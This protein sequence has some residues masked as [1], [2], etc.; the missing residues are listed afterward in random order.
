MRIRDMHKCSVL[1]REESDLKRGLTED[2]FVK[3][4]HLQGTIHPFMCNAISSLKP[5]L[6]LPNQYSE[7][8]P[9]A[10]R[11]CNAVKLNKNCHSRRC[12]QML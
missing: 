2:F 8:F 11:T 12:Y 5:S 7:A 1:P 4:C 3:H 6:G 10:S 9:D